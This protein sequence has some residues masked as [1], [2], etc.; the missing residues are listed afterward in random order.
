MIEPAFN[1]FYFGKV[2]FGA[3]ED[4]L[5]FKLPSDILKKIDKVD[6]SLI[7]LEVHC[8][9]RYKQYYKVQHL[10]IDLVTDPDVTSRMSML[11][12]EFSRH[13]VVYRQL[14]LECK[15]KTELHGFDFLNSIDYSN[16]V[17]KMKLREEQLIEE[18]VL[19]RYDMQ[20][21]LDAFN[22][23]IDD[24]EMHMLQNIYDYS[25][26]HEYEQAVFLLGAR[27]RSSILEKIAV[28]HESS[29]L[30][31]NWKLYGET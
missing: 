29:S 6:P 21:I 3:F 19:G 20:L 27:H 25:K 5:K 15:S 2:D 22:N 26:N 31:L 16:I 23:E 17:A 14:E 28:F 12:S 9:K 4:I 30:Q 7:P 11:F 13:D 10:P 1:L 24:R 18:N 8:I